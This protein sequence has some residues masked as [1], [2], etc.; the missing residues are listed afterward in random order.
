MKGILGA[1]VYTPDYMADRM[2]KYAKIAPG[3]T[4]C[5]PA[6]GTGNILVRAAKLLKAKGLEDQAVAELLFGY[7]IVEESVQECR[8]RLAESL[9]GASEETIADHIKIQDAL[10][11]KSAKFSVVV[12]NPP[13]AKD[14]HK[15]FLIW[16]A[17][18]SGKTVSIQPC[19]FLYKHG[20]LGVLDYFA[21]AAVMARCGDVYIMNPNLIWKD[22]K[23]ASPVGIFVLGGGARTR[24]LLIHDEMTDDEYEVENMAEICK[25][26]RQ[27]APFID[28]LA[29]YLAEN[30]DTVSKH[31]EL[32]KG[33][34]YVVE[35]AKIR[36]HISETNKD[37]YS[38]PD[39]ATMVTKGHLPRTSVSD[40]AKQHFWFASEREAVHFIDYLKTTF[41]RLCLYI[42]KFGLHID[43]HSMDYIPWLDFAKRWTEEELFGMIG[44]ECPNLS[45][46]SLLPDYY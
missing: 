28:K 26:H 41:A 10:K 7:D 42:N 46:P 33:S 16:A 45:D 24:P 36:G 34:S 19:Q 37:I 31:R 1:E 14:L 12:M 35:L 9:P 11:E 4:V 23:F 5:D 6:C 38:N 20:N 43:S 40:P 25:R 39:F 8:R 44:A 2:I 30:P 13:Y 22:H 29:S 21:Q 27:M 17:E 32:G 3:E 15:K 18:R